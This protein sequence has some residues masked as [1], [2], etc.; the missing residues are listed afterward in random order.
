MEEEGEKEERRRRRKE[1]WEGGELKKEE[2][3]DL[4]VC[5]DQ[6][7]NIMWVA[8]ISLTDFSSVLSS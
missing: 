8:I 4:C 7:R 3:N 2:E 5:L 6:K 1:E